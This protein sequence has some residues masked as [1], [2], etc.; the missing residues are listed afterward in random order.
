MKIDFVSYDG[1]Y[2]NLCR[3]Q[4]TIKYGRKLYRF[5]YPKDW[6]FSSHNENEKVEFYPAF[7]SSGGRIC[8][9]EEWEM[10][11]EKG[12]WDYDCSEEDKLPRFVLE[13]KDEIMR[14][15]NANVRHGCC[16]GCI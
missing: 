1:E 13:N 11:A 15:F 4:L 3:G 14:M 16:G 8:R 5:G 7:W 10:W 6:W 12:E 9:N 2:P